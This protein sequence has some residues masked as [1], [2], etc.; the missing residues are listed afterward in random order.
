M[1]AALAVNENFTDAPEMTL[2][3]DELQPE[4]EKLLTLGAT[5]LPLAT[6]GV[7]R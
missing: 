6:A 5:V 7:W 2:T 3:L 1:A 4:K